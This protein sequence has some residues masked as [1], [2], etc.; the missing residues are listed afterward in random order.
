MI[1]FT[2]DLHYSHKNICRILSSWSNLDNCRDFST[3]EQMNQVI[4]DG[5]NNKV[6]QDDILY[7]LGDWSLGNDN[8]INTLR[9]QI[10]CKDIR[11]I[12]GN[13]DKSIRKNKNNIQSIFTSV[14]SYLEIAIDKQKLILFHYPIAEWNDK[15]HGSIMLHG[16]SHSRYQS[17]EKILDVG[18]DNA[19]K[20][21][22]KYE[23]FS[24]ENILEIINDKVKN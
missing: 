13:H 10:V 16:H 2:S 1:Y 3:V 19:Y 4:V 18:I 6:N 5:I 9:I 12:L 20:L 22:G 23:P 8:N 17:K 7:C 14:Q 24:Y 15:G 21:L 11:Y